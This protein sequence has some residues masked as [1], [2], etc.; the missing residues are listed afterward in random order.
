MRSFAHGVAVLT[1]DHDG[2]R[3]GVTVSSLVSLSLEPPLVGVSIGK[4][5]SA[6]ELIRGA[7]EF[8]VSLLAADQES[9]A[10][11]FSRGVPPIAHWDGVEARPGRQ[12]SAPLLADAVG[13]LECRMVAAHDVGDH[14][15]FVAEP[16]VVEPGDG[17]RRPLIYHHSQYHSL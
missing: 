7:G 5:A 2:D 3:L 12:V 4:Q 15:F 14:T 8:G 1:V 11:R 10:Q 13:W 6:Y 16:V 9:L 17:D